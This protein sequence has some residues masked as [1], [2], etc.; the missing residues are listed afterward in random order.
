MMVYQIFGRE[1]LR[2]LY[3]FLGIGLVSFLPLFFSAQGIIWPSSRKWAEAL[4]PLTNLQHLTYVHPD[5]GIERDLFP[6]IFKPFTLSITVFISAWALAVGSSFL[7]AL[8]LQYVS[9]R[10]KKAIDAGL[11]F[12]QSIPDV[13]FI[14][15]AQMLVIWLS[16]TFHFTLLSFTGAGDSTAI[17]LPVLILAIVPTIYLVH[18]LMESIENE[19][20]ELYVE[21]ARSK[22]HSKGPLLWRHILRNT[23]LSVAYRSKYVV[24]MLVSNLL[25]V[26]YLFENAGMT[27]F[28]FSFTQPSVFLVTAV[29]FFLP[30]YLLLKVVE[31]ST[32]LIT[33]QSVHL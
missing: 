3:L 27:Q 31:G 24:S 2:V 7:L 26:E 23:L 6:F 5:S 11:A 12:L 30:I 17:V 20:A 9:H 13:I 22:G 14:L 4:H 1:L 25:I 10:G 32:Y 29:L 19:T 18:A 21:F 28:L 15:A 16:Q 8:G 33:N